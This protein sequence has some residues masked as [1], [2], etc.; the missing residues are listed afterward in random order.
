MGDFQ[1]LLASWS[2]LV[3]SDLSAGGSQLGQGPQTPEASSPSGSQAPAVAGVQEQG[4]QLPRSVLEGSGLKGHR[5]FPGAPWGPGGGS[6]AALSATTWARGPVTSFSSFSSFSPPPLSPPRCLS[7]PQ[8]CPPS[9]PPTG[10]PVSPSVPGLSWGLGTPPWRGGRG[11][12]PC[13]P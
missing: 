8:P 7:F 10:T 12:S 1:R 2:P 9:P 6:G 4:H 11:S 13:G 5:S 3:G